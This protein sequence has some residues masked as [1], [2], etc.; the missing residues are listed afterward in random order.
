ML[1]PCITARDVHFFLIVTLKEARCKKMLFLRVASYYYCFLPGMYLLLLLQGQPHPSR[2]IVVLYRK[3][4]RIICV[5]YA[6]AEIPSTQP[7]IVILSSFL[8]FFTQHNIELHIQP[9]KNNCS[10]AP[11]LS[12]SS[13][14]FPLYQYP[15]QSTRSAQYNKSYAKP[16][17]IVNGSNQ[18]GSGYVVSE[19]KNDEKKLTLYDMAL[20][21]DSVMEPYQKTELSSFDVLFNEQVHNTEKNSS[22][23]SMADR[24]S[25]CPSFELNLSQDSVLSIK[26]NSPSS[27]INNGYVM[28]DV[29]RTSHLD[30]EDDQ[31]SLSSINL[32][33]PMPERN[34]TCG[35]EE[36]KIVQTLPVD[37]ETTPY[38]RSDVLEE[39]RNFPNFNHNEDSDGSGIYGFDEEY[40]DENSEDD[41][42]PLHRIVPII[43]PPSIYSQSDTTSGYISSEVSH[44]DSSVGYA[45]SDIFSP[46]FNRS[47][48]QSLSS[49]YVT[50]F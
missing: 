27:N 5:F 43:D 28:D 47:L 42:E 19:D 16:S 1:Y 22:A 3:Q 17:M 14:L 4:K 46:E 6:K 11:S 30:F 36:N 45:P 13:L 35:E 48:S 21:S 26:L 25:P 41:A 32:D 18:S 12:E 9:E 7:S 15:F 33:H 44:F 23:D 49:N 10:M 38:Q 20:T 31:R 37:F 2:K 8:L 40:Y 24:M 50:S 29:D 34:E 39:E